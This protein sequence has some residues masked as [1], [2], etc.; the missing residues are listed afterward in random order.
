MTNHALRRQSLSLLA[1]SLAVALVAAPDTLLPRPQQAS[2]GEGRLSLKDVT[3]SF[4]SAPLAEDLF[5]ANQLAAV[6]ADHTGIAVPVTDKRATTGSIVIYRTG[7]VAPLPGVDDI[8]GPESREAYEVR[9]TPMGGEV[10][11]RSSAGLFYAVQTIRQLVTESAGEKFIPEVVIRDWPAM[12]YRGFMM[13]LSHGGLPTED[14]IK[15]QIDFLARWKANQYYFYSE[16]NIALRGHPLLNPGA[17]YTEAQIRRIVDYARE[18]HIDIVPCLEFYGHL[19]DLFRVERYSDLAAMPHGQ[20]LNPADPRARDLLQ[21]WVRQFTAMFP[22]PWLHIGLDEPWE[23]EKAGSQVA[24][25]MEPARLYADHLKWTVELVRQHGKRPMFWADVHSGARIFDKYPE[26]VKQL[27]GDAVAVPWNYGVDVDFDA[28]LEPFA[29]MKVPTV[30]APGIMCWNEIAPDFYHTFA[31]IDRFLVSGRKHG[32]IGL[33]NTGWT[34]AS[35]VL[36]RTTLAAMAYGAAATWQTE[37]MEPARFFVDYARAFYP[38]K[39]AAEVAAGLDSLARAQALATK[40]LGHSTIYRMWDD[41]LTLSRLKRFAPLQKELRD[42]R[43]L[44]GA[45]QEHLGRAMDLGAGADS[46]QSLM[47]V[48][49]MLDYTGMKYI[50]A[51]EIAGYWKTLGRNP[52]LADVNFYIARQTSARNHGRVMDLMDEIGDLRGLYEAAWRDEYTERRMRSVLSRWDA[53]LEYWR[54]FQ[55]N[56]WDEIRDFKDGDNLPDLEELRS[57]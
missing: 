22:S 45:A 40:V 14:E 30:I 15:R 9:I 36:Y 37:P 28:M 49:R 21:N 3:I 25:G 20:D 1:L 51:Q 52:N 47:V 13:D 46:L 26:L 19:H 34:D 16:A 5:A 43:L 24:G 4:A 48:A 29:R 35:Q 8:T 2:Y 18:R 55:T 27:P 41:P 10:R 39:A 6:L 56:L 11:A 32:A 23:L 44:A 53:E 42:V 12:A 33:I 7:D 31:N 57:R 50:Y 38:A 17:V 54:R